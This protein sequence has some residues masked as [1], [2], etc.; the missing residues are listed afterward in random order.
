MGYAIP[1]SPSPC[2]RRY[3]LKVLWDDLTPLN[4]SG[5]LLVVDTSYLERRLKGLPSSWC[6]SH[7]MP[8]SLTPAVPPESHHLRFL[9]I[10]FRHVKTVANCIYTPDKAELLWG[11]T[12]PLRL[13]VF[14][15]Y[16][17]RLLFVPKEGLRQPRNTR[18]GLL[19]RLCPMGTSCLMAGHPI[20]STKLRL[21]H[22]R[23]TNLNGDVP[24]ATTKPLRT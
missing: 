12:S 2:N 1:S 6:F 4:P 18:Y 11:G 14:P 24:N 10:G 15:V 22:Q 13:A 17:S 8:R 9:C 21:A 23:R 5:A 19:V 7:Y 16:A 3:R 20:R